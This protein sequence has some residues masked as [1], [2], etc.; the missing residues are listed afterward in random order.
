MQQNLA[1]KPNNLHKKAEDLREEDRLDEAEKVNTEAIEEYKLNKDWEGV[2]R[3]LQS[4]VLI[5][6]HKYLL[7]KEEKILNLA[8][9]DATESLIIAKEHNLKYLLSVC[10]FRM[11]EVFMIS[12][13]YKSAIVFFQNAVDLFVGYEAEKGDYVYH[14]GEALYQSGDKS[15]GK[16]HLLEGLYLIQQN[17]DEVDPFLINV[18]ESGCYMRLADCFRKDDL[19]RAKEYLFKA[20][21]IIDNDSKLVIR[22]RQWGQLAKKLE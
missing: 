18:W 21:E 15:A 6:K 9:K 12:G 10:N 3:A 13:D 14:L 17:K 11:G 16:K 8:K 7:V 1:F 19:K 5:Y 22:R 2:A 20:K 4:R